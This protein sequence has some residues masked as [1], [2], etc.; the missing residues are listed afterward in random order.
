VSL[1]RASRP[2]AQ[3]HSTATESSQ[4]KEIQDRTS[5]PREI[6]YG[7]VY[8][9]G[10]YELERSNRALAW[11]ALAAGAHAEFHAEHQIKK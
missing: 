5:P 8:R 6:V 9:E 2:R 3:R 11:S 10:E 4:E 1:P 7:A